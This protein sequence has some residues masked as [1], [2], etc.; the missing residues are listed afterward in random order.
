MITKTNILVIDEVHPVLLDELSANEVVYRP[1]CSLDEL[2]DLLH[3]A[4]VLILRSKLIFSREWIDKGPNLKVIGRL[5]SGMDNIDEEYAKS[6]GI[7]CLNAPEGNRNAVAEQTL[8]ML[9]SLLA[10][11]HKSANEVKSKIWDRKGNQGVE[12]RNLTVGIIGYGNVGSRLAELLRPFGC[13]ILAYDKFL[14][15]YGDAHVRES[16]LEE[17][18]K[19]AHIITC[20]TPLNDSSYGMIDELFVSKMAKPFYLL[21]L[22]RGKV[23]E[24]NAV[25]DGLFNSKILG[26]GLDVLPN[27]KLK[28]LTEKEEKEFTFLVNKKNVILTPHIGGLTKDSYELLAKVLGDK[29][30][31]WIQK[32]DHLLTETKP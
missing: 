8:G 6:K 22:S 20:H 30:N 1:H 31:R 24:M 16:S 18:H 17:L 26:L 14:S 15:D 11:I 21:N 25:V 19:Y 27:E 3:R 13:Q 23:L 2:P 9:L 28:T 10:N 5:G 4:E 32:K 29:I 7:T 12:L